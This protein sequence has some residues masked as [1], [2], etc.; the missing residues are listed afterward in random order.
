MISVTLVAE[1]IAPSIS[2]SLPPTTNIC[3]TS[4]LKS[5]RSRASC[6][7]VDSNSFALPSRSK[8]ACAAAS[9]NERT[10]SS[11]SMSSWSSS[12]SWSSIVRYE[13]VVSRSSV[14]ASASAPAA[15]SKLPSR[16][17]NSVRVTQV[18]RPAK[19]EYP[20]STAF[21]VMPGGTVPEIT[22]G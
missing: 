8:S 14:S 12:A 19:N 4:S 17:R 1:R 10:S 20:S 3:R 21:F 9:V 6:F 15:A 18:P 11:A 13:L 16:R 2:A 7:C 5:A 22:H